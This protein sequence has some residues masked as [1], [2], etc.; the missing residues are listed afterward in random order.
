M[1]TPETTK[2]VDRRLDRLN[3]IFRE[4]ALRKRRE[5]L[6]QT[7]IF[8]HVLLPFEVTP[9]DLW[10]WSEKDAPETAADLRWRSHFSWHAITQKFE[11]NWFKWST[12]PVFVLCVFATAAH[13]L[14][15]LDIKIGPNDLPASVKFGLCGAVCAFIAWAV[16]MWRCPPSCK[17]RED[18][19]MRKCPTEAEIKELRCEVRAFVAAQLK[20]CPHEDV[21]PSQ[22]ATQATESHGIPLRWRMI[23]PVKV[24]LDGAM[25][26][27]LNV[28]V[29]RIAEH[30]DRRALGKTGDV[31]P[32]S[33]LSSSSRTLLPPAMKVQLPRVRILGSS[34][35][36][37]EVQGAAA[38][39]IMVEWRKPEII[40]GD[41][42]ERRA[43]RIAAETGVE[44]L[45]DAS[46]YAMISTYFSEWEDYRSPR[47]RVA[48]SLLMWAAMGLSW[49]VVIERVTVF[50]FSTKP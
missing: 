25:Y 47:A 17:N 14:Q 42:V 19:E 29:A 26:N 2:K 49:F 21:A 1:P 24:G 32:V 16:H 48:C 15:K 3:A 43:D 36:C 4:N 8:K 6:L 38:G 35:L 13:Y 18:R 28:L 30:L 22:P 33:F 40:E 45:V 39:D 44:S 27:Y 12:T 46:T 23:A 10:H 31:E 11:G 50:L 5:F 41:S 7:P 37:S 9:F 34:P 20:V